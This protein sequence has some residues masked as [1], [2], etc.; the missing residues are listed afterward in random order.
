LLFQDKT[1]PF[2][3]PIVT[4]S[5]LAL[6]G[7]QAQSIGAVLRANGLA[8]Q[9]LACSLIHITIAAVGELTIS[10]VGID[11][12]HA[13]SGNWS[14]NSVRRAEWFTYVSVL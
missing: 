9:V 1:T 4:R 5:T 6:L 14:W 11:G 2:V 7:R 12:F 3:T 13:G 10:G 8:L